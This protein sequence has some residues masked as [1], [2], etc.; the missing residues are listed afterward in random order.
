[1]TVWYVHRRADNSIASAHEVPQ[2]GYAEE[3]LD[4]SAPELQAL[5]APPVP[6]IAP[7]G[8]FMQAL[9]RLGWY[10]PLDSAIASIPSNSRGDELRVLWRR[11]VEFRRNDPDLIAVGRAVGMTDADIDAVFILADN[12]D[13]GVQ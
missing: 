2:P 12:L 8:R 9:V 7:A 1:M 5:F 3:P 10:T 4:A 11:A 6:R 13:R